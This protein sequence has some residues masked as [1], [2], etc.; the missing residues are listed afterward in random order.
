M[1]KSLQMEGIAEKNIYNVGPLS[2]VCWFI[3]SMNTLYIYINN[4][5]YIY[6]HKYHKT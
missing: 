5:I 1:G 4:H 2:D 6:T 3:N